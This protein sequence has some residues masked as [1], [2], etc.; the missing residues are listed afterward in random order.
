MTPQF[1]NRINRLFQDV[2]LSADKAVGVWVNLSSLNP[3]GN[4]TSG[5]YSLEDPGFPV[6]TQTLLIWEYDAVRTSRVLVETLDV[7]AVLA[8]ASPRPLQPVTAPV[9]TEIDSNRLPQERR[10]YLSL[11]VRGEGQALEYPLNCSSQA[12]N[13]DDPQLVAAEPLSLVYYSDNDGLDVTRRFVRA[14]NAGDADDWYPFFNGTGLFL[15]AQQGVVVIDPV[16]QDLHPNPF[17]STDLAVANVNFER[18]VV[19]AEKVS[20]PD[21][22]VRSSVFLQTAAPMRPGDMVAVETGDTELPPGGLTVS[23]TEDQKNDMI[24]VA[25]LG[26][27]PNFIKTAFISG[28]AGDGG[29][30]LLAG[31]NV[32]RL[33]RTSDDAVVYTGQLTWRRETKFRETTWYQQ[34]KEA[35]FTEFTTP[36]HYY[37]K[38]EYLGISDPFFID[39]GV[40]WAHARFITRGLYNMRCGQELTMPWTRQTHAACHREHQIPVPA[41]DFPVVWG[42]FNDNSVANQTAVKPQNEN[43]LV[44]PYQRPA[45]DVDDNRITYDLF[46]G[47]HDAGDYGRYAENIGGSLWW[48]GMS[49]STLRGGQ[50]DNLGVPE[51]GNGRGDIVDI[52]VWE[53]DAALRLQEPDGGFYSVIRPATRKYEDNVS[54]QEGDT[55]DLMV[56]F[57]K[58]L[59][60]SH[61]IAA[62]LAKFGRCPQLRAQYGDAKADSYIA[63]AIRTWDWTI[64]AWDTHGRMGAIQPMRGGWGHMGDDTWASLCIELYLATGDPRYHDELL[65]RPTL[66]TGAPYDPAD[67]VH[68][69]WGWNRDSKNPG[70]WLIASYAFADIEYPALELDADWL[71]KSKAAVLAWGDL[72]LEGVEASSHGDGLNPYYKANNDGLWIFSPAEA[73]GLAVA[74]ELESDADKR[75]RYLDSYILCWNHITGCNPLN[76][77]F[78]GGI[79]INQMY[80]TVS[81]YRY[82]NLEFRAAPTGI[83]MSDA[84]KQWYQN[85]LSS[86]NS[87]VNQY[88]PAAYDRPF[89]NRF[90]DSFYVGAELIVVQKAEAVAGGIWLA[91]VTSPELAGQTYNGILGSISGVNA[92]PEVGVPMRL[93]LHATGV[94]EAD[95]SNA[96]VFWEQSWNGP[97]LEGAQNYFRN[98][99]YHTLEPLGGGERK[100]IAEAHL[101]DGRIVLAEASYVYASVPKRRITDYLDLEDPTII[102]HWDFDGSL[103]DSKVGQAFTK[104]GDPDKTFID[105]DS[106]VDTPAMRF[107]NLAES[108]GITTTLP[109]TLKEEATQEIILD[110]MLNPQWNANRSILKV[111]EFE[112]GFNATVSVADGFYWNA[113]TFGLPYSWE[114]LVALTPSGQWNHWRLRFRA[115]TTYMKINDNVEVAM[116]SNFFNNLQS[117]LDFSF[118]S[119]GG[120]IGPVVIRRI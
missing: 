118:R 37:I 79:G 72:C 27:H 65:T 113:A 24:H 2:E 62:A 60:S 105:S 96:R 50:V 21:I 14:V 117:P 85:N 43:D 49:S 92:R 63:A 80:E 81:Q 103:V 54:L 47:H 32:F 11:E 15:P 53:A 88:Y 90:V 98:G 110:I 1:P 97:V 10:I 87:V 68:V 64:A 31:I 28:Y 67:M 52:G 99:Q 119:I 74:Y 18:T 38:V 83:F 108:H 100:I 112:A 75:R 116:E 86:K 17:L 35:N 66:E 93:Q 5:V 25:P 115:G 111:F 89:F 95:L 6:A 70:Y 104:T 69:R 4:W 12:T 77:S 42:Q 59:V 56:P 78:I 55:G 19:L 45:V 73:V 8:A 71:A 51:S 26:Y 7:T 23:Y 94:S 84:S 48:F 57:P 44:F 120:W 41:S 20:N 22:I 107:V 109:S 33:C 3:P 82:N 58:D 91:M 46:G 39:P 101:V 30:V 114:D 34:V 40:T 9:F 36:G 102:Y 13:L 76:Q 61:M 29:E 16:Y 106:W